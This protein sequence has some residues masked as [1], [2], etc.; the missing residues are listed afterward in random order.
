MC[1]RWVVFQNHSYVNRTDPDLPVCV[2]Q[3]VLVWIP[4]GFLWLC[5]PWHLASLCTRTRGTTRH[6]SKLYVCKQVMQIA[7]SNQSKCEHLE[8][9]TQDLTGQIQNSFW[10]LEF[11]ARRCFFS[12]QLVVS[13]LFLTAIAALA[14]T[15][16]E[17]YGPN[18]GPSST[19]KHPG[20]YY[21]NPVL[22]AVSWVNIV[23]FVHLIC[24]SAM[25]WDLCYMHV[26]S[27]L[28][29]GTS[30]PGRVETGT[31]SRL[32]D[33]LPLLVPPGSVWRFPFPDVSS[34]GTQ[35]GMSRDR[36]SLVKL[37]LLMQ[38]AFHVYY[39]CTIRWS[40]FCYCHTF[41][42]PMFYHQGEINDVPRSSLLCISFGLEL[43]AL[44]LSGV[45]DLSPE[46]KKLRK[47]VPKHPVIL[48]FFL[49]F[50]PD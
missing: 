7:C 12:P 45:A 3:T 47:K 32:C 14:L 50:I 10:L 5:V 19:V 15:L 27:L 4:L 33:S 13:L 34:R 25:V 26:S 31:S 23:G 11:N 42:K 35:A 24:G 44:V 21:A 29:P 43:I 8:Q 28:D 39:F 2:E 38:S 17:D 20:V 49:F 22:F 36:F 46:A 16:G 9:L 48:A 1:A 6:L 41:L 30:G 37:E 40:L 18:N